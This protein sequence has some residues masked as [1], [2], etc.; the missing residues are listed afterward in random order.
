MLLKNRQKG[1]KAKIAKKLK[2]VCIGGGQSDAQSAF[3]TVEK[4]SGGI[5][6][7]NFDGGQRRRIQ[8]FPRTIR[9][10]AAGGYPAPC[11]GVVQRAQVEKTALDIPFRQ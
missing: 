2:I 4:I 5:D 7:D 9:C 10:F 6:R 8:P 11:L 3:G 1:K